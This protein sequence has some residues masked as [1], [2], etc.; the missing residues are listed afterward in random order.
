MVNPQTV[1]GIIDQV[2][3]SDRLR[4]DSSL[5]LWP[6]NAFAIAAAVLDASGAYNR[7]GDGWPLPYE[8]LFTTPFS[9]W[10]GWIEHVGKRWRE[11]AAANGGGLPMEVEELWRNLVEGYD[12]PLHE[13]S[14]QRV[15]LRSLLELLAA[16]DVA[17]EDAGVP[18]D[19]ARNDPFW[20]RTVE[21]LPPPFL[22][23]KPVSS[24]LCDGIDP[25]RA[26]VLPKMK[27]PQNGMTTR[28]LS[29][30]LAY[31]RPSG[32]MPQW[33]LLAGEE[34]FVRRKSLNLLLIPWPE[35][36]DP[37]QFEAVD[38]ALAPIQTMPRGHGFFR[39][40]PRALSNDQVEDVAKLCHKAISVVGHLDGL[41][42]PEMSLLHEDYL[43][44]LARLE[45]LSHQIDLPIVIAGV[46]APGDGTSPCRN[47]A[48]T[49]VRLGHT[50]GDKHTF[51]EQHKHHRWFLSDSQ[52]AAYGLG[53]QLTLGGKWWEFTCMERRTLAFLALKPWLALSV[54]VC[55]DLARP[56]PAGEI[57]RAVGPNLVVCLLQDGPQLS[58][59][60]SARSATVLTDDPSTSVLT[61]T[62]RGMIRLSNTSSGLGNSAAVALWRDPLT[63]IREITM[64][65]DAKGLVLTLANRYVEQW[66]ADGRS[67]GGLTGTVTLAGVHPIRV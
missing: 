57:I 49:R 44:V 61:L 65:D 28:S 3:G 60:W 16:A 55:E 2:V 47:Y 23:K 48:L 6:P 42:F 36:I 24:T 26:I 54:L 53:T 50:Q 7:I 40:T 14:E 56:D 33:C 27:T 59:R 64:P 10:L 13:V 34:D 67:D 66:T 30:H 5:L 63:G 17:S 32:V 21:I 19:S 58:S 4:R 12:A 1:G 52:I 37:S 18:H 62:S 38:E 9:D 31:V 41:V 22:M 11:R 46:C 20:Q 25:S 35:R 51:V 15:L 29:H 45:D 39:Y 43:K 8:P